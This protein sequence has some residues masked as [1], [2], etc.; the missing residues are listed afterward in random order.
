MAP[1]F[2]TKTLMFPTF[3]LM[4]MASLSPG[5]SWRSSLQEPESIALIQV[6]ALFVISAFV[7]AAAICALPALARRITRSGWPPVYSADEQKRERADRIGLQIF[8]ALALL[9]LLII[10]L[11]VFTSDGISSGLFLFGF[12]STIIGAA[13]LSAGLRWH[14]GDDLFCARCAYSHSPQLPQC[15]ECG[16]DWTQWWNLRMGRPVRRAWLAWLGLGLLAGGIAAIISVI[17][18]DA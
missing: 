9:Y 4:A 6:I 7:G 14:T 13:T 3:A 17:L 8:R 5:P 2:L 10:L 16:S 11:I 12:H 18:L 1:L 15:P